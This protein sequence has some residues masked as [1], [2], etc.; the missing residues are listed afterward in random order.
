VTGDDWCDVELG[1]QD[2]ADRSHELEDAEGLD[3]ADAE[4]LGPFP[5]TMLCQF[6]TTNGRLPLRRYASRCRLSERGDASQACHLPASFRFAN[7]VNSVFRLDYYAFRFV[8]VVK[9]AE[10]VLD[11]AGHSDQKHSRGSIRGPEAVRAP[12]R[13]EHETAG[14]RGKPIIAANDRQ[15][16]FEDIK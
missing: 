14:Q 10:V 7:R 12:A 13:H 11:A 2:Q 9:F 5:T 1:G 4:V 3:E 15:L 8:C 16:T 6:L